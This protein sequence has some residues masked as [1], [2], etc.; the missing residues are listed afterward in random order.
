MWDPIYQTHEAY[1]RALL[2]LNHLFMAQTQQISY[3]LVFNIAAVYVR[4]M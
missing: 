1:L 3:R 4:F 2:L